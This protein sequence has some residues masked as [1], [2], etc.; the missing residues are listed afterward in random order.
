MS[1]FYFSRTAFALSPSLLAPTVLGAFFLFLLKGFRENG[2]LVENPL[3]FP[4]GLGRG[5]TDR[6]VN[7]YL[8]EMS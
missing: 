2:G 8:T 6:L 7:C 1:H 5:Y 4:D 3:K